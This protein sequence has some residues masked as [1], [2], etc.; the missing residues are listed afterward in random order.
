MGFPE[1]TQRLLT[2][3]M[4]RAA[5]RGQHP[6]SEPRTDCRATK[7][8]MSVSAA[9][10]VS[11]GKIW[12]LEIR[13]QTVA[14]DHAISLAV[15]ETTTP[16]LDRVLVRLSDAANRSRLWLGAAGVIAVVGGP[17]G[18]RAAI[19]ALASVG[20]A[21]AVSNL[22]VKSLAPRSRPEPGRGQVLPSRQVRRPTS[23]SFP[24]GHAA[25]A[26]A[27]ASTMGEEVPVTWVPLHFVASLVAYSRVHTGVHYPSDVLAGSLVGAICGWTVRRLASRP[28]R[29][30][31]RTGS[32]HVSA[33]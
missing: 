25:S 7:G 16:D 12:I 14:L 13:G 15:E 1:S 5:G 3:V 20:L 17:R 31:Q 11:R 30:A 6:P 26:F 24:S 28:A 10:G 32:H 22:A 8:E 18:R 9:T 19:T 4:A 27:F 2:K 21:S 33:G 29:R 23:P